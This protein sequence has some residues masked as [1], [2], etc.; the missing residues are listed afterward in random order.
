[1]SPRVALVLA[2]A[3]SAGSWCVACG[4]DRGP[5]TTTGAIVA[6]P[7]ARG[8]VHVGL[9]LAERCEIDPD[10]LGA[11]PPRFSYDAAQIVDADRVVLDQLV[12]CVTD[13]ELAGH[14]LVLVG[15]ADP[16][17]R[18]GAAPALHPG[19]ARAHAVAHY[20]EMS[21]VAAAQLGEV[22]RGDARKGDRRVD[23][24]VR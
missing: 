11:P 4:A 17:P 16:P 24:E 19:S 5:T 21:G 2:A 18:D 10:R 15:S 13:G 7:G 6:G 14:Q 1:M 23:V 20:L 12:A 3:A 8:N 9:I 22:S